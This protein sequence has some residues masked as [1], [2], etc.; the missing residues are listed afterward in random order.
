MKDKS[1]KDMHYEQYD[2]SRTAR[3]NRAVIDAIKSTPY[4]HSTQTL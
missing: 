3:A 2:W 4:K 1:V